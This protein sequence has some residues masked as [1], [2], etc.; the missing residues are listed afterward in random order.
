MILA[1]KIIY[2]KININKKEHYDRKIAFLT[3]FI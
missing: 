1:N 3:I 2:E